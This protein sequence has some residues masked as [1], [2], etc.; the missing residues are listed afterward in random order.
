MNNVVSKKKKTLRK[1]THEIKSKETKPHR[2]V[3][4]L[5]FPFPQ[6][7]RKL[8]RARDDDLF[9]ILQ[10]GAT[11]CP[12]PRLTTGMMDG[13]ISLGDEWRYSSRWDWVI[14]DCTLRSGMSIWIVRCKKN[15]HGPLGS[16]LA[17]ST[18]W[19]AWTLRTDSSFGPT[20]NGTLHSL[21]R[22]QDYQRFADQRV[23]HRHILHGDHDNKYVVYPWKQRTPSKF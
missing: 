8:S 19:I 20:K 15:L 10:R 22:W 2:Q 13:W 21:T 17:P 23:R 6:A 12:I 4:N 11:K 16:P 9:V 5:A 3:D 1:I 14:P 7:I 18:G